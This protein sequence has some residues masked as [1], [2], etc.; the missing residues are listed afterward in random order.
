MG[1][2]S[3]VRGQGFEFGQTDHH[4]ARSATRFP[5]L[6]GHPKRPRLESGSDQAS[7]WHPSAI[8]AVNAGPE[9]RSHSAS[10]IDGRHLLRRA[11][12]AYDAAGTSTVLSG[13]LPYSLDQSCHQAQRPDDTFKWYSLISTTAAER[14]S[15][16]AV[17]ER[18][19]ASMHLFSVLDRYSSGRS[20][21]T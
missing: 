16:D 7:N 6:P 10:A 11:G 17:K 8:Y 13:R 14:F 19:A 1:G 12:I 3:W 21:E 18:L 4:R 9:C 5:Y 20:Q 2:G 15:E